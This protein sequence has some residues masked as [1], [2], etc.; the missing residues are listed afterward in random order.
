[1]IGLFLDE[2]EVVHLAS[3]FAHEVYLLLLAL[4]ARMDYDLLEWVVARIA[5]RLAVGFVEYSLPDVLVSET[6]RMV[7][8]HIARDTLRVRCVEWTQAPG[9]VEIDY[10]LQAAYIPGGTG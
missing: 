3:A 4:A 9:Q 2:L 8:N 10:L 1:V 7:E 6:H 5:V